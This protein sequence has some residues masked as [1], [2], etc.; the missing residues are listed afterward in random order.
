MFSLSAR[1]YQKLLTAFL[2]HLT[3]TGMTV[4]LSLLIA[5]PLSLLIYYYKP[6]SKVI[7]PV[8]GILYSIPSLALFALLIPVLHLGRT[9][10]LVVLVA[11][12]QFIL[13]RNIFAGLNTVDPAIL[14]AAKGMG[15]SPLR[16]LYS[17]Q[18]PLA[19]PVFLGGLRISIISTIGIATI[20]ATINAGGLGSI[21]FEGLRT[22]DMFKMLWG[23]LLAAILSLTVNY[24][25]AYFEKKAWQR[26]RGERVAKSHNV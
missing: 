12:N 19:L 9:P 17:I 24:L 1:F 21:L 7:L 18:L 2:E 20:A 6:L 5:I 22:H 14:E 10:A 15:L 26:A 3:L 23:T 13:V 11:Y 8:L 4:L 16:I 25:I